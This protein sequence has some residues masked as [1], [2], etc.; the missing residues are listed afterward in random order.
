MKII[1]CGSISAGDEI[2]K[3]RKELLAKGNEV[4]IPEGVKRPE[5]RAKVNAS[6][7]EKADIKVKYN[8]IKGYYN[9]MK[10]FDIVLIVNPQLKGV[11]GYIGRNTFLEM[12]FA[13][14]LGKKLYCLY[15]LPQMPYLSELLAMK[16]VILSRKLERIRI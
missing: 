13:H 11:K 9:K 16:P 2:V 5:I 7:E 6:Q 1:I 12:G 10:K 4:E 15:P 14:V 8:L 3:V